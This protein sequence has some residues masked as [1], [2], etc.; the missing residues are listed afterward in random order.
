MTLWVFSQL[1]PS[2][3]SRST[4]TL[5]TRVT[6]LGDFSPNGQLLTYILCTL[7]FENHPLFLL[8]FS[9]VWITYVFL[10]TKNGFGYSLGDFFRKVIRPPCSLPFALESGDFFC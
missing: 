4:K 5:P 1:S 6:R 9:K 3:F 7:F 10:M 8:L 2:D